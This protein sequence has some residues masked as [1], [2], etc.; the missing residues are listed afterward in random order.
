[1]KAMAARKTVA[2]SITV[3]VRA[4]RR[5]AEVLR[6]EIQRLATSRGIP[7]PAVGVRRVGDRRR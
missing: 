6:L 1:V 5:S 7:A 3:R 2:R 4:S